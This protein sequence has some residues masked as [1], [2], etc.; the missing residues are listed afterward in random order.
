M[1]KKKDLLGFI[2][3]LYFNP[4]VITNLNQ[5]IISNEMKEPNTSFNNTVI[6]SFIFLISFVNQ[7]KTVLSIKLC[8]F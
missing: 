1:S 3:K 8:K 4:K 2:S 7:C 5:N 6:I